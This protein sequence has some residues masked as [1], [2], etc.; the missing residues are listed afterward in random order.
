MAK[1]G[2]STVWGE[3]LENWKEQQPIACY[4]WGLRVFLVFT[5][6]GFRDCSLLF[7]CLGFGHAMACVFRCNT[8]CF[9]FLVFFSQLAGFKMGTVNDASVH[10]LIM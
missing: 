9:V 8:F 2:Q 6:D 7:L 1:P 3:G 10:V 5:P 4:R